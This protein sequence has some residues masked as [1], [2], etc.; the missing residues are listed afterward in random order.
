MRAA[1]WIRLLVAVLTVAVSGYGLFCD[2]RVTRDPGGTPERGAT[3]F[4]RWSRTRVTPSRL[5][6]SSLA[7]WRD[8]VMDGRD[9]E[10]R[11]FSLVSR[12]ARADAVRASPAHDR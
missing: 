9:R 8:D 5:A 7:R 10:P 11:Q 1:G 3:V 4:G 2:S 12:A 6:P